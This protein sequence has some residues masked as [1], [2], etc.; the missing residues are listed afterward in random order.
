MSC[1]DEWRRIKF[2]PEGSQKWKQK[3][4]P[5]LRLNACPQRKIHGRAVG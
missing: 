2:L 4:M 5:Q 1:H 3:R